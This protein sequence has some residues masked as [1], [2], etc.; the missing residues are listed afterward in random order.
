MAGDLMDATRGERLGISETNPMDYPE[1]T[2]MHGLGNAPQGR[3]PHAI[4]GTP[5][6]PLNN[7]AGGVASGCKR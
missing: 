2:L 6:N 4:E 5:C 7:Y 1:T 3:G